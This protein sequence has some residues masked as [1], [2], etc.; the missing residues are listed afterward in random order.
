MK[1]KDLSLSIDSDYNQEKEIIN[2]LEIE[3]GS[4]IYC[5]EID[6]FSNPVILLKP[7]FFEVNSD[8]GKHK[9]KMDIINFVKYSGISK[10]GKETYDLCKTCYTKI[11]NKKRFYINAYVVIIFEKFVK[12]HIYKIII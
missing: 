1:K 2:Q 12:F 4:K 5:P 8:C 9:N 3:L 6:F 11:I 7:I 10:E